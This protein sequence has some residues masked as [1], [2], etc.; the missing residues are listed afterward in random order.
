MNIE[1]KTQLV[2]NT[3]RLLSQ[4][5]TAIHLMPDANEKI[6]ATNAIEFVKDA[7]TLSKDLQPC[8]NIDALFCL[9]NLMNIVQIALN[10]DL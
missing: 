4:M 1:K 3:L 9:T 2:S 10:P 5:I 8:I 6:L 7:L